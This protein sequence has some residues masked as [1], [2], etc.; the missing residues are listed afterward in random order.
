M[1]KSALAISA[2]GCVAVATAGWYVLHSGLYLE[3][4]SRIAQ[5][6]YRPV[7]RTVSLLSRAEAPNGAK[8]LQRSTY[9]VRSDGARATLTQDLD[10]NTQSVLNGNARELSFPSGLNAIV[11]DEVRLKS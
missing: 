6:H 7:P 3:F 4:K 9:F 1:T 10:P 5:S 2:L 11:D 8:T